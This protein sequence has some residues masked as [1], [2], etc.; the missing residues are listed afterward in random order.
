M[1]YERLGNADWYT[2]DIDQFCECP[3]CGRLVRQAICRC[4]LGPKT[5]EEIRLQKERFEWAML[6]IEMEDEQKA[7]EAKGA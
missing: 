7:K 1:T 5:D 6:Q 3:D 4:R 2:R